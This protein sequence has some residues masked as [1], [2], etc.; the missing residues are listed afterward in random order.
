MEQK[1][2]YSSSPGLLQGNKGSR[3]PTIKSQGQSKGPPKSFGVTEADYVRPE[4]LNMMLEWPTVRTSLLYLLMQSLCWK[5]WEKSDRTLAALSAD[6]SP[7]FRAGGFWKHI[8]WSLGA[9]QTAPGHGKL[10]CL[11]CWWGSSELVGCPHKLNL[12]NSGNRQRWGRNADRGQDVQGGRSV[13]VR[14]L[15][16]CRCG[17]RTSGGGVW[18]IEQQEQEACYQLYLWTLGRSFNPQCWHWWISWLRKCFFP[19]AD[20]DHLSRPLVFAL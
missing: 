6:V 18:F 5:T 8:A 7:L 19:P 1:D 15:P 12:G 2:N 20:E 14:Q 13:Q 3:N 16:A 4:A 17:R 11:P 9:L 10:S